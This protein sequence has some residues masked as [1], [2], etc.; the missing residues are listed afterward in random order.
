MGPPALSVQTAFGGRWAGRS[1]G[2][3][4][5]NWLKVL[6]LL[7]WLIRLGKPE[8]PL[9]PTLGGA[10]ESAMPHGTPGGKSKKLLNAN[11]HPS[12]S[13]KSQEGRGNVQIA[14]KGQFSEAQRGQNA[15]HKPPA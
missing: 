12:R 15:R 13:K 11:H 7:I 5:P 4:W 9:V 6:I 8:I 10:A 14:C 2:V 3:G 1:E